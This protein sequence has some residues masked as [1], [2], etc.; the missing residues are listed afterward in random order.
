[1][2]NLDIKSKKPYKACKPIE[3][4]TKV[5]NILS[6]LNIYLKEIHFPHENFYACSVLIAS[7][8]LSNIDIRTNGK[9][10]TIQYAFASAHAEFIERIQNYMLFD[11]LNYGLKKN[12]DKLSTSNSFRK[13]L[14]QNNLV[15][16]FLYDP[17]ETD[18]PVES[19]IAE[20]FEVLSS[21]FNIPSKEQL[22]D[23]L[24]KD[25][26]FQTVLCVPFYGL[27]EKKVINLP[28]ELVIAACG[29][30]GMC[31]GN[32]PK[33]AIIQ[34]ICEI[35]ERYAGLTIYYNRLTPPTIPQD[36][37]KNTTIYKYIF[38][39]RLPVIP[40]NR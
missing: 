11:H 28:I 31:A 23:F 1:M 39:H 8:E 6:P 16:D 22:V 18:V 4:I 17:N 26:G 36:Y 13:R 14:E 32:T 3:T 10:M 2:E 25:L 40:P 30:N 7:E 34:G 12:V 33:E 38:Q 29:S 37:F 19:V 9:G 24:K 27:D 35:M 21:M 15:L 5:R 20:N